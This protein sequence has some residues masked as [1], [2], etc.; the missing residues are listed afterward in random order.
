MEYRGVHTCL[1]ASSIPWAHDQQT[2]TSADDGRLAAGTCAARSSH[3]GAVAG[4]QSESA[5]AFSSYFE[6]L[7]ATG[8]FS[9]AVLI[10]KNGRVMVDQAH[11]L[12][13]RANGLP[14]RTETKFNLGSMNK[15]FTAVAVGQ[16]VEQGKLTFDDTAEHWLPDR[17]I[18]GAERITLHHLLTHTSGLGDLFGPRFFSGSKDLFCTVSDYFALFETSGLAF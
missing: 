4:G 7:D 2:V 10:T 11:G 3:S 9:G 16:L 18:A 12:A 13:D 17:A 1:I 8:A 15:M 6:S 5:L 14:N